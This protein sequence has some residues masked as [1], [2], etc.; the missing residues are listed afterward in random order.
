[1]TVG[2][3]LSALGDLSRVTA[4]C[5]V[6]GFVNADPGYDR[7]TLVLNPFSELILALFGAEVGAQARTVIGVAAL[8]LNLPVVVSAELTIR[9]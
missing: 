7:T 4:W 8:P 2:E 5:T 6:N 9:S 1:M 3:Q